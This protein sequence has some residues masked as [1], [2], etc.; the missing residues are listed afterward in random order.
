MFV[1]FC[2]T[3]TS[4]F[5]ADELKET[6]NTKL[7]DLAKVYYPYLQ[8]L[9]VIHEQYK[10]ARRAKDD[11]AK[12]KIKIE[13]NAVQKNLQVAIEKFNQDTPLKGQ[14]LPFEVVSEGLPFDV[15]SIKIVEVTHRAVK[16]V[17]Q[18]KI[19]QDIKTPEGEFS[20][21]VSVYFVAIDTE[22]KVIPHTWNWATND[23]WIKLK[24]DTIYDTKGH[25]NS[26]RVQN[27]QD[28]STVHIMSKADYKKMKESQK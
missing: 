18:V 22:G 24:K 26:E 4:S 7:G 13:R 19:N 27:M 23:G 14:E 21:R 20:Q 16:F 17:I 28:F 15:Q 5:Y 9:T 3:S 25:W 6:S 8:K 2:I 10:K 1:L 11:K 12:E